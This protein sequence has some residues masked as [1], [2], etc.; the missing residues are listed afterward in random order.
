MNKEKRLG[1]KCAMGHFL[2]VP[3]SRSLTLLT[4]HIPYFGIVLKELLK[5]FGS[6]ESVQRGSSW[7]ALERIGAIA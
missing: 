5:Y 6:R 2:M 3:L 7:C 4:T 1:N